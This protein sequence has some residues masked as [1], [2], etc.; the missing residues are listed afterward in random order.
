MS[1]ETNDSEENEDQSLKY[2]KKA[3]SKLKELLMTE[4][5]YVEKDL[6]EIVE[7]YLAYM[8][9]SKVDQEGKIKIPQDLLGGKDR[10]IFGNIRAI[11]EVHKK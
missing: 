6:K 1:E 2:V 9:Q 8:E 5:T 11:Y 4:K 7:G 10:I 3:E